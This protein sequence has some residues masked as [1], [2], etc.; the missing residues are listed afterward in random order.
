MLKINGPL[1]EDQAPAVI[2]FFIFTGK[3]QQNFIKPNIFEG[4]SK[5][6]YSLRRI[7]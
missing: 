1:S 4:N 7:Y 5:I 6:L 2:Q 3:E